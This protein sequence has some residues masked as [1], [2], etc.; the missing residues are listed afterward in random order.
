MVSENHGHSPQA[1]MQ[2]LLCYMLQR[3]YMLPII[4]VVL[5][6]EAG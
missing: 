3:Y 1:G 2:V 5:L 4:A 6:P